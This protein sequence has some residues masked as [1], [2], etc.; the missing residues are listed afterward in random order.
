VGK[1]SHFCHTCVTD[2]R[3]FPGYADRGWRVDALPTLGGDYARPPAGSAVADG[4]VAGSAVRDLAVRRGAF[5]DVA[6]AL[7]GLDRPLEQLAQMLEAG[8]L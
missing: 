6:L 8:G 4:A 1:A 5:P 3:R 2:T 7:N